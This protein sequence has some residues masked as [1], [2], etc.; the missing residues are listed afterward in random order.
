M[1]DGDTLFQSMTIKCH[2]YDHRHVIYQS[3]YQ[4]WSCHISI[5]AITAILAVIHKS[6]VIVSVIIEFIV[7][8]ES[9]V[10]ICIVFV[11]CIFVVDIHDLLNIYYLQH[12]D[13]MADLVVHDGLFVVRI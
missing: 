2:I 5:Y 13:S 7:V 6:R 12:R 1:M 11:V 9:F 3:N 4:A 10:I 8:D